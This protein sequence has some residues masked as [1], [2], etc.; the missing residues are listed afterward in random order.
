MSKRLLECSDPLRRK[1]SILDNGTLPWRQSQ[2]DGWAF[3]RPAVFGGVCGT[4][5]L[6]TDVRGLV[7][8]VSR[9]A[10]LRKLL[11]GMRTSRTELALLL[12]S[13][14]A[15]VCTSTAAEASSHRG[16][17]AAEPGNPLAVRAAS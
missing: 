12:L 17:S 2:E 1:C 6:E 14:A 16:E 9:G 3:S 10:V 13:V 7:V 4:S 5:L 15:A 8:A 11:Q